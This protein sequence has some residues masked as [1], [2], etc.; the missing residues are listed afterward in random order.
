MD[1][2]LERGWSRLVAGKEEVIARV[3]RC[4]PGVR[5]WRLRDD[6]WSMSDVVE[7][8]VR[9]EGGMASA[10]AKAPS[11]DR[12]RVVAPGRWY[13]WPAL[14]VALR[15]GLRIK[16]PVESIL[17]RRELPWAELL[18]RWER[19]RLDL[20][21]WLDEAPTEVLGDPRFRHP[22]AGWLTVGQAVT[23][24]GDHLE[25]HLAQIGRIARRVSRIQR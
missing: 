24:A 20:G 14:R 5:D 22:I 21:Q 6:A 9:S 4:P 15:G 10:L 23:F 8:L 17:P 12:P 11:P 16:A 18:G 25:H 1:R 13:R 19:I 7:H 2:K 3:D